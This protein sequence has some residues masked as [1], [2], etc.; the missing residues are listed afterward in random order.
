MRLAAL[1]KHDAQLTGMVAVWQDKCKHL[2]ILNAKKVWCV[3]EHLRRPGMLKAAL[4][5]DTRCARSTGP[6]CPQ[7]CDT[8]DQALLRVSTLPSSGLPYGVYAMCAYRRST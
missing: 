4:R 7:C 6:T 8:A 3:Y 1:S 2:R 5:L